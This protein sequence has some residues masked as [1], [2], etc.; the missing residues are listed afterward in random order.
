M[1]SASKSGTYKIQVLY[2]N[3]SDLDMSKGGRRTWCGSIASEPI[4]ITID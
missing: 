1:A 2:Y 3:R 4:E